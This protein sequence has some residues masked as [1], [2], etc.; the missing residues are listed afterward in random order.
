M[1]INPELLIDPRDSEADKFN[2]FNPPSKDDITFA[3]EAS[4]GKAYKLIRFAPK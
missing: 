2:T 1:A 4:S 3:R